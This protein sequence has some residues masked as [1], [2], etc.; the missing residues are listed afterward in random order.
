MFNFFLAI[1]KALD[2]LIIKSVIKNHWKNN[3][4]K[5][6]F[7]WLPNTFLQNTLKIFQRYIILYV[8]YIVVKNLC[9]LG[10]RRNIS[11]HI[12]W[13]SFAM[14]AMLNNPVYVL[15]FL[16]ERIWHERRGFSSRYLSENTVL[17]PLKIHNLWQT[18]T[19]ITSYSPGC[20]ARKPVTDFSTILP[21]SPVSPSSLNHPPC[22][23]KL[24]IKKTQ[25]SMLKKNFMQLHSQSETHQVY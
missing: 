15:L 25:T 4:K 11:D 9:G 13:F 16:S 8:W 23:L 3:K 24:R 21:P 6:H 20:D 2:F 17:Q 22:H 1:C 14:I 18:G 12:K 19:K 10:S 7:T 5:I